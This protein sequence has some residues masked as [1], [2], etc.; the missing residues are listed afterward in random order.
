MFGRR[1]GWE[2]ATLGLEDTLRIRKGGLR[3][4]GGNLKEADLPTGAWE[5][6]DPPSG[7][8]FSEMAQFIERICTAAGVDNYLLVCV[9]K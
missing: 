5:R 7:C 2:V 1:A 4:A 8:L 6:T 9:N 3:A